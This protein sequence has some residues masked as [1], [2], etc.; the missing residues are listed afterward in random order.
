ML[1][2][3]QPQHGMAWLS[4]A[5]LINTEVPIFQVFF[6]PQNFLTSHDLKERESVGRLK[7][8]EVIYSNRL[9]TLDHTLVSIIL[10]TEY[11]LQFVWNR[12]RKLFQ[13]NNVDST[14]NWRQLV[15]LCSFLVFSLVKFTLVQF[16]FV[17]FCYI[18]LY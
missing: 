7:S 14:C 6:C 5:E 16:S 15:V 9:H 13:N 18:V 17:M 2:T 10:Y 3:S 12:L 4:S 8:L 11:H 1:G